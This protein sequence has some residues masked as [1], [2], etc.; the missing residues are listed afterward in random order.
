M[1]IC[2][3]TSEISAMV[4]EEAIQYLQAPIL[5]VG[6]PD[7]PVPFSPPLEKIY[8]PDEEDIKEAVHKMKEYL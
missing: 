7:T 1:W 6:S 2:G 5:R 4:A 8:I 3:V